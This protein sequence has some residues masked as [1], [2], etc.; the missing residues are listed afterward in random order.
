MCARRAGCI[1]EKQKRV[2]VWKSRAA[3]AHLIRG[4]QRDKMTLLQRARE[5]AKR[6][7]KWERLRDDNNMPRAIFSAAAIATRRSRQREE[8]KQQKIEMLPCIHRLKQSGEQWSNGG[9]LEQWFLFNYLVKIIAVGRWINFDTQ[10]NTANLTC[11][12]VN[13]TWLQMGFIWELF[14]AKRRER[15]GGGN[16]CMKVM[17][18]SLIE[19]DSLCAFILILWHTNLNVKP[20]IWVVKYLKRLLIIWMRKSRFFTP[21][22]FAEQYVQLLLNLAVRAHCFPQAVHITRNKTTL[23]WFD[24]PLAWIIWYNKNAAKTFCKKIATNN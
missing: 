8:G 18:I 6:E 10:E 7:W 15:F 24:L 19:Y 12:R 9:G 20:C 21:Y 3:P 4:H 2:C 23:H 14:Y 16:L 17:Q 11:F 1:F 13:F 22:F 5:R